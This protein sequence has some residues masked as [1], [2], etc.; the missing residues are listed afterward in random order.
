MPYEYPNTVEVSSVALSVHED[1]TDDA[2]RPALIDR[3]AVKYISESCTSEK[4][5]FSANVVSVISRAKAPPSK[6][7]SALVFKSWHCIAPNPT[8]I[9]YPTPEL[10]TGKIEIWVML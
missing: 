6:G 4:Y 7:I 2:M 8:M 1:T 3:F 5:R 10:K 9:P